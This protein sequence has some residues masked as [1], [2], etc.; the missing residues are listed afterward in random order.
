MEICNLDQKI[1]GVTYYDAPGLKIQSFHRN[2]EVEEWI[3]KMVEKL[4]KE[5]KDVESL[6]VN[7][8][9]DNKGQVIQT[10]IIYYLATKEVYKECHI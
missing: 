4:T 9:L 1:M 2:A 7:T 5:G 8:S 3:D 10:A 6:Q